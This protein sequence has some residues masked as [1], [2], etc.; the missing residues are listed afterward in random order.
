MVGSSNTSAIIMLHDMMIYTNTRLITMMMMMMM[1]MMVVGR[2][3]EG[4]MTYGCRAYIC[5]VFLV[6]VS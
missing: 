4:Y 2:E 6:N 3:G 1:K 5:C